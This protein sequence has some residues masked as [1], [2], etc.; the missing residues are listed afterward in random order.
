[1][2]FPPSNAHRITLPALVLLLLVTR[3]WFVLGSF[4]ELVLND[5]LTT[6]VTWAWLDGGRLLGFDALWVPRTGGDALFQVLA[7]P[8]YPL[9]GDTVLVP[10]LLALGLVTAGL[11]LVFRMAQHH[12]G[13]GAALW[14]GLLYVF[15]PPGFMT[16][17]LTGVGDHYVIALLALWTGHLLILALRSEDLGRR[18][19]LLFGA[20]LVLGLGTFASYL[21]VVAWLALAPLLLGVRPRLPW[22][23]RGVLWGIGGLL[24][25]LAPLIGTLLWHGSEATTIYERG[26]AA[27]L[28]LSPMEV[29]RRLVALLVTDMAAAT[30]Y[31]VSAVGR[32]AGLSWHIAAGAALLGCLWLQRRAAAGLLMVP[33]RR[34]RLS[35]EVPQLATYL[36]LLVLAFVAVW[37]LSDFEFGHTRA[38]G[39]RYLVVVLPALLLLMAQALARL[40][41]RWPRLQ[42]ALGALPLLAGL[43]GL[44]WPASLHDPGRVLRF[45]GVTWSNHAGR[46]MDRWRQDLPGL[47]EARV[48]LLETEQ[49]AGFLT[50]LGAYAA[51]RIGVDAVLDAGE[52][53]LSPD[54]LIHLHRGVL[55]ELAKPGHAPSLGVQHELEKLE[56]RVPTASRPLFV[57]LLSGPVASWPGHPV[58][59]QGW[60]ESAAAQADPPWIAPLMA[61]ALGGAVLAHR[62]PDAIASAAQAVVDPALRARVWFGAGYRHAVDKPGALDA[63]SSKAS[64]LPAEG[65][66]AFLEG[67]ARAMRDWPGVADDPTPWLAAASAL[68]Q[69]TATS[70]LL[71]L[72]IAANTSVDRSPYRLADALSR[73]LPPSSV[74]PVC[75]GLGTGAV[76]HA[77]TLSDRQR[78]RIDADR[79]VGPGCSEAFDRGLVLTIQQLHGE[80]SPYTLHTLYAMG[81][82][83]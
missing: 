42:L 73:A 64:A 13:P 35:S 69:A 14:A 16:I 1:M 23:R 9:L 26:L 49:R 45:P 25:G 6:G 75:E 78:W 3:I 29:G 33:L 32:L 43:A 59:L 68:P 58:A 80:T 17:Q 20:G 66:S 72:G 8:L 36:L 21:D 51:G 54:D 10:R 15:I 38:F 62:G 76:I 61:E 28:E 7:V 82:G 50:S 57:A 5:E 40:G 81:M 67:A 53:S 83:G 46:A 37:S 41:Q 52:G 31:R 77:K 56:R 60:L 2:T 24:L 11:V 39:Y 19:G 30:W 18:T 74:E 70:F 65:R 4:E 34:E 48:P 44:V 55:R 22:C 27:H 79:F 71:Q 12:L 63:L 47:L